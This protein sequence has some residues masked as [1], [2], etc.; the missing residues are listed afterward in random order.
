M[1]DIL[2][3]LSAQNLY[4]RTSYRHINMSCH[5]VLVIFTSKPN[6][7]MFN[8]GTMFISC[9]AAQRWSN[10]DIPCRSYMAGIKC[11]YTTVADEWN[12]FKIFEVF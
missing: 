5:E 1:N 6:C 2:H 8:A 9:E 3:S 4:H 10:V 11:R 12:A 7:R